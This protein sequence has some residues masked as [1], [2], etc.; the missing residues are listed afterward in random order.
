M[1][2][3]C[4]FVWKSNQHS[5]ISNQQKRFAKGAMNAKEKDFLL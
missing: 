4:G 2:Q 3:L 5:A 1:V